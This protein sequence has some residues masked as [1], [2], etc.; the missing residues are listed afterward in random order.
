MQAKYILLFIVL[1]MAAVL[2]YDHTRSDDKVQTAT[3]P[4]ANN[5]NTANS[6]S[7]SQPGLPMNDQSSVIQST[8]A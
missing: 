5:A 6:N 3:N 8:E 7:A 2:I 1:A 4:A